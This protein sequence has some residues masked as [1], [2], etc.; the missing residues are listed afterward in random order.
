MR[1]YECLSAGHL[2]WPEAPISNHKYTKAAVV[3]VGGGISAISLRR[4]GHLHNI[5]IVEKSG[6]FGG[7]WR[8]SHYPGSCC[9][10][11]SHLYCYS[12]ERSPDWP[13]V[14]LGREG[15]LSYLISVANTYELYKYDNNETKWKIRVKVAGGKDAEY[16][17]SYTIL[18]DYLPQT[19]N[20]PGIDSLKGRI[21]YLARWEC[22]VSLEGKKVAILGQVCSKLAN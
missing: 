18:S 3:I 17:D 10:V 19:P 1:S 9:D 13:R 5:I 12:F 7:A 4:K 8:D 21:M 15:I 11:F 20:I 6:G 2:P 16:G 22:S 14:Y